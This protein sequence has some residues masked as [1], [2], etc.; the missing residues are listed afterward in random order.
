TG[1]SRRRSRSPRSDRRRARDRGRTPWRT[2]PPQRRGAPRPAVPSRASVPDLQPTAARSWMSGQALTVATT[3]ASCRS[4]TAD[5]SCL[6]FRPRLRG[7]SPR[8]VHRPLING[9]GG[10]DGLPLNEKPIHHNPEPRVRI[11]DVLTYRKGWLPA[12]GN[13]NPRHRFVGDFHAG[14]VLQ[15]REFEG[16]HPA[17]EVR[18][19]NS[20][21]SHVI[22]TLT[23]PL[24]TWSIDVSDPEVGRP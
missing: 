15:L 22:A 3:A 5:S 6:E 1:N 18:R 23:K 10:L 12:C 8:V 9:L 14:R 4:G 21:E 16:G 19:L 17:P 11:K 20:I 7:W 24:V 13:G 2:A